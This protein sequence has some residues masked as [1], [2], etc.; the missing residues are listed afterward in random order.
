MF[1]PEL[2]K[3]LM[4]LQKEPILPL[5]YMVVLSVN[6]GICRKHQVLMVKVLQQQN[7]HGQLLNYLKEKERKNTLKLFADDI[8]ILFSCK[9]ITNIESIVI[10]E[11]N[12]IHK[13][14]CTNKLSLNL[15]KKLILWLVTSVNIHMSQILLLTITLIELDSWVCIDNKLSWKKSKESNIYQ[16]SCAQFI[17]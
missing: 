2:K 8:N 12:K 15:S 1:L 3:S 4:V 11:L 13:W 10:V 14:L 16:P 17:L 7:Q 9:T 6:H 5:H